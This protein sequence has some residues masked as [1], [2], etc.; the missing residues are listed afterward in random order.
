MSKLSRAT[1]ILLAY[2]QEAYVAEAIAGA[3]AQDY[4]DLEI[5]LSDDG[6]SDN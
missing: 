5:I 3:L 4:P 1:F 6:S 2:H